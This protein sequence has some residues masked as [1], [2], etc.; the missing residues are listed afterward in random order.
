[1]GCD[2]SIEPCCKKR[3]NVTK[4][5][6]EQSK[7]YNWDSITFPT[8]LKDIPKWEKDNNIGVNVFRFDEEM[9]RIFTLKLSSLFD[10]KMEIINLYLHDLH[11]C[12]ITDLLKLLA[13]Q[14]S[15]RK[16]RKY[17]C[18][19]CINE[20]GSEKLLVRHNEWCSGK[21]LQ[22]TIYPSD[23]EKWLKFK[24]FNQLHRIPFVV[25][26]ILNVY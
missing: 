4:L 9:E 6:K 21:E 25:M 14:V 20:F 22:A 1:M 2:K 5:L 11:Y 24:A 10:T 12:P 3:E 13:T 26:Q 15:R 8:K 18:L 16:E 7:N 19:R 23:K 17:F